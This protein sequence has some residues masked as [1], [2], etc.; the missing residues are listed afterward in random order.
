MSVP[1]KWLR[2]FWDMAIWDFAIAFIANFSHFSLELASKANSYAN[3][4]SRLAR[5]FL[6]TASGTTVSLIAEDVAVLPEAANFV[7]P[8]LSPVAAI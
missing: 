5:A 7:F 3:F 8:V 6:N 4:K 1:A 2:Q